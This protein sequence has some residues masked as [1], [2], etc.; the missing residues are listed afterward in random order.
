MTMRVP[1]ARFSAVQHPRLAGVALNEQRCLRVLA[2][3]ALDKGGLLGCARAAAGVEQPD[4]VAFGQQAEFPGE[5]AARRRSRHRPPPPG[6]APGRRRAQVGGALA[7]EP[8]LVGGRPAAQRLARRQAPLDDGE[9]LGGDRRRHRRGGI[10]AAVAEGT[11]IALPGCSVV[12][13]AELVKVAL[14]S[15]T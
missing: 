10:G 11:A 8:G 15:P 2:R 12:L 1:A 13:P 6:A 9:R 3:R 14:P 5:R 7:L 4:P